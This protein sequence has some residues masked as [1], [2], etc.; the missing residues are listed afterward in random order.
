[1]KRRFIAIMAVSMLLV[2]CS[3]NA[4]VEENEI[5]YVS[6]KKEEIDNSVIDDRYAKVNK[7]KLT[8]DEFEYSGDNACVTEVHLADSIKNDTSYRDIL[9]GFTYTSEENPTNISYK[10]ALKLVK[11]VLP[12]DI[13]EVKSVVDEEV[14]KEYIYYKSNK[15]NFRVGLSYGEDLTGKNVKE[16]HEGLIVGIDYSKEISE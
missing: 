12:D 9:L 15:G 2:G 8:Y 16:I 5:P 3:L 13:K 10:E 11:K 1:M 6:D 7:E 4:N 14:S